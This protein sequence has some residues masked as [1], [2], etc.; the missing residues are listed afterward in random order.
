MVEYEADV[1]LG[2]MGL[3]GNI[4]GNFFF[5]EPLNT[6]PLGV[7]LSALRGKYVFQK[8]TPTKINIFSKKICQF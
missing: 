7:L 2:F 1:G 4:Y 8:R 5:P 3:M 6:K